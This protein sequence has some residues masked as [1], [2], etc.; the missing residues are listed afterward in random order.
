[1]MICRGWKAKTPQPT[2]NFHKCYS[3]VKTSKISRLRCVYSVRHAVGNFFHR[4]IRRN[5]I[6]LSD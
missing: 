1:M 6:S 2:Q 3:C 4:E 5:S